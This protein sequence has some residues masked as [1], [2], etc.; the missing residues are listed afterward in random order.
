MK[1][2]LV[3]CTY[4]RPQALLHLLQS[5]QRQT[6]YPDAV[7]IVDGSTDRATADMLQQHPF[8]QLTYQQ[9]LPEERGL[10][11]QRN[12]GVALAQA[13]ADVISFLDDDTVLDVRYFEEI[14]QTFATS[15]RIVGVG[16]YINNEVTWQV[17]PPTEPKQLQFFYKEGWRRTEGKRFILRKRLGLDSNVPP[18]YM[19]EYGHG[20]SIGFLPPTGRTYPVEQLM[21]GVA[22]YRTSVF[23]AFQFS[24][25]FEGYGLYEDAD[26]SLR[27]A[28][29]GQ[30]VVNTRATLEHHHEP[31]GRP[32]HFRYGKMVVRNGWYVW[33]VKYTKPG[34][35]AQ[36]KWHSITLL[37]I[38]IR[39]SNIFTASSRQAALL[40]SMGRI[41][42]WLSLGVKR[43]K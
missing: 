8:P 2:A 19:P 27:V 14:M 16:G 38:F 18:G 5:V 20:R 1:L 22:T 41:V 11:K 23:E 28:Q 30:L 7:W 25:F 13:T 26:F 21:G 33:R 31:S 29:T 32:N 37:L 15:N 4:M 36:L 40:E 43:P 17:H 10:T 3:I 24:L 9:V 39:L 6:R 34:W 35:N 42:G 12:I